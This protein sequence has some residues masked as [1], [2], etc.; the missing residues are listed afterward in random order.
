MLWRRTTLTTKQQQLLLHL[1][2]RPRVTTRTRFCSWKDCLS[3]SRPTCCCHSS[4][5]TFMLA[6]QV[7]LSALSDIGFRQIPWLVFAQ[8]AASPGRSIGKFRFCVRAIRDGEAS[9]HSEGS[10]ERFQACTGSHNARQLG[11]AGLNFVIESKERQLMSCNVP[12]SVTPPRSL[13]VEDPR[14]GDDN[15][16]C[17]ETTT[18]ERRMICERERQWLLQK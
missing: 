14:V 7:A 6:S 8:T 1:S 10:T 5:S 15:C 12:S 11:Q 3:T 18:R 9:W 13:V 2:H 16:I 17:G 4:N